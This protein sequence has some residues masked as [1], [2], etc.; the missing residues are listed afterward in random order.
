M[1]KAI[2]IKKYTE[3]K[4]YFRSLALRKGTSIQDVDDLLQECILKALRFIENY[5]ENNMFKSWFSRIVINQ[6]INEYKSKSRKQKVIT[7]LEVKD[8]LHPLDPARPHE[9]RTE[10][11][12]MRQVDKYFSPIE[13]RIIYYRYEKWSIAEMAE[14]LNMKEVTVRGRIHRIKLK[15]QK[16]QKLRNLLYP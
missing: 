4:T 5:K 8:Y 3:H 6:V 10:Q 15:A 7:T 16:N 12:L 1:T 14:K 13:L 2:L 11:E 9:D